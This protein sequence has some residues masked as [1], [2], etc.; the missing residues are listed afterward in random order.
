MNIIQ[1]SEEGWRAAYYEKWL[2]AQERTRKKRKW[3]SFRR[4]WANL[5]IM[6]SCSYCD[7]TGYGCTACSLREKEIC[8]YYKDIDEKQSR[9]VFWNYATAMQAPRTNWKRANQLVDQIV[10]AI[11]LDG[12]RW[13][14]L[15]EE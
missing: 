8:T 9:Y 2:K 12:V 5:N 7:E 3:D 14:Y 10:E 1:I 11:R 6:Q 15:S 4:G 13:G